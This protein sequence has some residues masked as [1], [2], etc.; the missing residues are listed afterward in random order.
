MNRI[1]EVIITDEDE[2]ALIKLL[3]I[4]DKDNKFEIINS[5]IKNY[6]DKDGEL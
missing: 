3:D 5:I 6:L 4:F 2:E 1:N